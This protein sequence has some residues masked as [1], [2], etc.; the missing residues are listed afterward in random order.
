MPNF[1]VHQH[2][3]QFE[4]YAS[5]MLDGSKSTAKNVFATIK[6]M[7]TTITSHTISTN[8]TWPFVTIP[9]YVARGSQLLVDD[10]VGLYGHLNDSIKSQKRRME[11]K[12]VRPTAVEGEKSDKDETF[13]Y[14]APVRMKVK[15]KLTTPP[16][17]EVTLESRALDIDDDVFMDD[18]EEPFLFDDFKA[19]AKKPAEVKEDHKLGGQDEVGGT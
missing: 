8:A 17:K 19:E 18:E 13:I 12:W 15:K 5:E 9:H 1:L 14:S 10:L 2:R 16:M 7:S 4:N 3:L 11:T 6:S